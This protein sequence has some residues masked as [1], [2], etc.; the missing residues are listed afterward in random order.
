VALAFAS[1]ATLGVA[2]FFKDLALAVW[3]GQGTLPESGV[4]RAW[5]ASRQATS[6]GGA[7]LHGEGPASTQ[8]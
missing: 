6:K 2:G 8:I 4:A 5:T 3:Q 1:S 7:G